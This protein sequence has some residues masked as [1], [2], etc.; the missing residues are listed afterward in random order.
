MAYDGWPAAA[1]FDAIPLKR[2]KRST[3]ADWI[4]GAK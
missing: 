1:P 4:R 3:N 2:Y